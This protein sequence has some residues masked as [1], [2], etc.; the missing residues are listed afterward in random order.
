[1]SGP[2]YIVLVE[3]SRL[4]LCG[5]QLIT[6]LLQH[7]SMSW[8]LQKTLLWILAQWTVCRITLNSYTQRFRR[9]MAIFQTV[10]LPS[11][12]SWDWWNQENVVYIYMRLHYDKGIFYIGS[13]EKTV[14]FREQSRVRKFRQLVSGHLGYYEP[15]LKLWHRMNNFYDFCIFPINSCFSTELLMMEASLQQ[16][17]QPQLNWP[18]INSL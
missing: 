18:W 17:C 3:F 4:L 5:C 10:H 7:L 16:T 1:M 9:L 13:T 2:T 6:I 12:F 11:E 8:S 14:F 15:A